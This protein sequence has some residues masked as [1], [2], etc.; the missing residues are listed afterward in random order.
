MLI[1]N[2]V[3][4]L[5]RKVGDYIYRVEQPSI[6]L[7]KTGKATVITV[8]TTSPWFDK[9][10]LSADVLILH[11][12]SEHD[13]LP[14][15]EERKRQ[16]RPTIYELSDNILALHEG[17]GI[18]RWFSD[19]VNLALAFQYMRM[20]DA[21]QVT[22]SGLAD[23]FRFINS[24]MVIFENQMATVGMGERQA[25]DRVILG[26]AGSSGHRRDIEVVRDV[27]A[28]AMR[29]C[30][31]LDF[32]YMGDETIYRILSAAL[33]AGRIIYTPPGT[34]DD[35]LGFLQKLD[36]GI[37]PLQDNPYNRCRSDVKFLE[38]ASRGVVPVLSS[39]TPYKASVQQG[40]TGFLYDSP[41]QLLS[42]LSTLACDAG[43]RDRISKTA[44]AYVK[45]CR[46]EDV[47]AD[48]RLTF[49]SSLIQSGKDNSAL[50]PEVPLV[51]CDENADYFEVATSNVERLI[52]EGI[53]HEVAGVY[54]D[55]VKTYRR[56]AEESPDYSL[57]WFW[58]GYCSLR[59]CNPDAS[60]WFDEAIKRN[61]HSLRACWL[62]AKALQDQY[63]MAALQDLAALLKR[64]PGYTPAAVSMAELLESHGVYAEAM[65]WY[66]EALR[67]NPFC[68]PA[69][70]GLGRIYDIQGA[71]E[72]AGIGFGTA[73]DLAPVW[74]E[75]QYRMA[76]WCFS[77]N[78]L[79]QAAEYCSRTLLADLSHS[80]A[81]GLI[82]EIK[83]K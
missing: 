26:W 1:V 74:A 78:D 49:Y 37:A 55:A 39:L 79:E 28:Q 33:P 71:R 2:A 75:A 24:R 72:Q 13:L 10:C 66:N 34:L 60:Q 54:E 35:Y 17:V 8:N 73:A 7:G 57:P 83:K 32:A 25:S 27:I 19:P 51:R 62:K 4:M 12:L 50:Y 80:G 36:I 5:T 68:S 59:K 11:L 18:R 14:L 9:L 77:V 21:I 64:W 65:H 63:P 58:L 31:H 20:A 3:A 61:P 43:L 29:F 53:N 30:P 48:S 76:R 40:E 42:I 44:Y 16:G 56:A 70:L 22:G 38:Y 82:E 23:Q 52:I 67:L 81:Q 45:R 15:L 46:M 41:E 69:A 47:H 6:A